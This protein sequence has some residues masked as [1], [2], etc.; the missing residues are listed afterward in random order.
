MIRAVAG[1]VKSW[2]LPIFCQQQT[3]PAA[4]PRQLLTACGSHGAACRHLRPE[5]H[6]C[7]PTRTDLRAHLCADPGRWAPSSMSLPSPSADQAPM[8]PPGACHSR[9]RSS[10]PWRTIAGTH[11]TSARPLSCLRAVRG[12]GAKRTGA[13]PESTRRRDQRIL[14]SRLS[15]STNPQIRQYATSLGAVQAPKPSKGWPVG[16]CQRQPGRLSPCWGEADVRVQHGEQA[17]RGADRL[18]AQRHRHGAIAVPGAGEAHLD[19]L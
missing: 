18:P 2:S 10:R 13:A 11:E 17:I 9:A 6:H 4:P 3:I 15:D 5:G 19:Q 14:Q 12:H 1:I 16:A 7:K 8:L